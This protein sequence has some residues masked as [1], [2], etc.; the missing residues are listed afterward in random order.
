M[1]NIILLALLV[2]AGSV[3]AQDVWTTW[4]TPAS[5]GRSPKKTTGIINYDSYKYSDYRKVPYEALLQSTDGKSFY[6]LTD[7]FNMGGAKLD[8]SLYI[9]D[10]RNVIVEGA[11][12]SWTPSM[13]TI[14]PVSVQQLKKGTMLAVTFW[15]DGPGEYETG[16][17]TYYFKLTGS[18]KAI[19]N[20]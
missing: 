15:L 18:S 14:L 10:E 16:F 9:G 3:S 12:A 5:P 20:F 13:G 7:P 2:A 8:I 19:T 4:E 17:V 6:V 11:V 1:R